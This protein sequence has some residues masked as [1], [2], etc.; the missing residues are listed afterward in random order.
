MQSEANMLRAVQK[1]IASMQ[2]LRTAAEEVQARHLAWDRD[3]RARG[4]TARE[5]ADE[6]QLR[7]AWVRLR[8]KASAKVLRRPARFRDI[9]DRVAADEA[10]TLAAIGGG[11]LA[12][13]FLRA[14]ETAEPLEILSGE[15]A[16]VVRAE[17][18]SVPTPIDDAPRIVPE[19][20][21]ESASK[22][23]HARRE[24]RMM[25]S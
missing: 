19:L 9:L 1:L 15:A 22:R 18:K 8:R 12:A 6:L 24:Q 7:C 13:L 4:M 3:C 14:Y 2:R 20:P 17:V 11:E 10:R 16:F 25:A 23:A 5:Q 21:A